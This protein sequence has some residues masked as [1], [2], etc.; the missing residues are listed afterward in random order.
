MCLATKSAGSIY[1][2]AAQSRS[3]GQSSSAPY[4]R[5]TDSCFTQLKA[6]GPSRTCNESKEEEEEGLIEDVPGDEVSSLHVL[7]GGEYMTAERVSL[8]G[9]ELV[10]RHRVDAQRHQPHLNLWFRGGLVF[11]AYILLYHSTLGVR[12]IKKQRTKT[13]KK[14]ESQGNSSKSSTFREIYSQIILL[15]CAPTERTQRESQGKSSN[16]SSCREYYPQTL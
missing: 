4:L 12:V 11:K 6:Q 14:R 13:T 7:D 1:S 8:G 2:T 15:V 3:A 10:G 16:A 9:P 5:L